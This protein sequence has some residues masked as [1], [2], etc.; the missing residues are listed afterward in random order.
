MLVARLDSHMPAPGA[1]AHEIPDVL[2]KDPRFQVQISNRGRHGDS[3]DPPKPAQFQLGR[4][5]RYV[6]DPRFDAAENG[7]F[8]RQLIHLL[9]GMFKVEYQSLNARS[10]LPVYFGNDPGAED[11]N[12]RQTDEYGEAEI[13]ADYASDAP[14]AETQGE[15]FSS[16]V[17]SLRSAAQ[18]SLQEV[19]AAARANVPLTENKLAN[20]RQAILRKENKLAWAGDSKYKLWGVFST[21]TASGSSSIPRDTAAATFAAGSADDMLTALHTFA[22]KAAE[23]TEV[24]E[25]D[26]LGLPTAQYNL[27]ATT[28]IG[29]DNTGA[30]VLQHFLA[31]NPYIRTVARVRE[32]K[33]AGTGAVD[34]ALAFRRDLSKVRLN[35]ML[36]TEI[37]PAQM[38]GMAT[39]VQVHARFGGVTVHKPLSLR[40]L[41][42]I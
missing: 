32:L 20:A 42:G 33:G 36:D 29:V 1:P 19:R 7:F 18:W 6:P 37:L 30:T 22:N 10:I 26:F 24:E 12:W 41:E 25:P 16:K 4:D 11:V 27:A 40:I 15:E 28:R 35:I 2:T 38:Q 39:R 21:D 31:T 3:L 14:L 34:V 23:V 13:V 9:P 5:M 8:A 17:K